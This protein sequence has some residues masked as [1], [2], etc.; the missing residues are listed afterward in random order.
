MKQ[1][2]ARA[3]ASGQELLLLLLQPVASFTLRTLRRDCLLCF[4]AVVSAALAAGVKRRRWRSTRKKFFYFSLSHSRTR[5]AVRSARTREPRA[6]ETNESLQNIFSAVE[7]PGRGNLAFLNSWRATVL[8]ENKL[9]QWNS[10]VSVELCVF[11]FFFFRLV[12]FLPIQT[13]Y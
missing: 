4:P 8:T 1:C 6:G 2:V 9:F 11:F 7:L 5:L 12:F 10:L 3:A 13:W